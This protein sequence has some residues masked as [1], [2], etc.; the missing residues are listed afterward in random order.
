MKT[1]FLLIALVV[2][3]FSNAQAQVPSYVPSNG[4]VGWWPFNGNANDESGN[5]NNGTVNGPTLTADRLGNA[6]K[7]YSF[8]GVNDYINIPYSNSLNINGSISISYWFK[9]TNISSTN[10]GVLVFHGD[11]QS[12]L[13]FETVDNIGTCCGAQFA[14]TTNS[15]SLQ[16]EHPIAMPINSW[17]Q[18]VG[19][20]DGSV[21]KLFQDGLLLGSSIASISLS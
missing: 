21:L 18:L 9:N 6:N 14:L 5:G 16:Y 20:Y 19:A 10:N 2:C 8:D 13:Q 15:G 3:L 12:G 17:V 7:A 4:L 1:K 11:N